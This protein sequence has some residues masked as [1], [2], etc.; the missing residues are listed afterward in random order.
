MRFDTH[1]FKLEIEDLKNKC[2]INRDNVGVPFCV[3]DVITVFKQCKIR[4]ALGPDNIGCRL[5]KECAEQLG[6]IFYDIFAWSLKIQKV[7]ARWKQSTLIPLPKKQ[8]AQL[9]DDF[10]PVAL[11]SLVMKCLEKLVKRQIMHKTESSLDPLQFAYRNK[12]GIEDAVATLLHLVFQHLEKPKTFVKLLFIDFSSAFNTIQPHI[13]IDKL[14]KEF[15][16]DF[17]LVGWIL[18]FLVQR[19]QRVKVNDC[20]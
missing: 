7:P 15:G 8:N 12:R 16:L 4:K 11:T 19:T 9:L 14:I 10:R 1:D 18:D 5:L 13:L 3:G 20:F 6:P 2:R 17:Y